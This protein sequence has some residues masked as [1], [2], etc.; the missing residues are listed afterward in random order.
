MACKLIW[1]TPEAERIMGYCARVSNPE[2]QE[3]PDVAKLLRFCIRNGHWSVF[4]MADM[5]V[6]ITT[7]RVISA[8]ITRHRSFHFQEFSQRYSAVPGIA[9][10]QARRQDSKNRQ[11][12]HDDLP[13]ET[14]SWFESAASEHFS[15]ARRLYDKALAKGIAKECARFLLPLASA[16]T[17]YMKGSVRDWIHYINLRTD[18]GTQLEHRELAQQCKEL[19]VEQLP[20]VGAALGWPSP[21]TIRNNGAV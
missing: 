6:E 5:C 10:V 15:Q 14:L 2:N 3:N 19:F 9:Q 16:T 4:E 8:Q 7:T 11:S 13:Q 21:S 17:L 18:G 12:S 20:I 1:I